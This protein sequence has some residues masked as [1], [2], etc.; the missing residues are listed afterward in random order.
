MYAEKYLQTKALYL[1]MTKQ[2]Q[3]FLS[4]SN[5]IPPNINSNI[6][7]KIG[8][9]GVILLT[10]HNS[11]P[12]VIIVHNKFTNKW[13]IP[14]GKLEGDLDPK[15]TGYREL[16]EESK[17]LFK[18][19]PQT[20]DG[21]VYIDKLNP[22]TQTI[23]RAYILFITTPDIQL[24]NDN[25][26]ELSRR[27]GLVPL[28]YMETDAMD[29]LYLEQFEADIMNDKGGKDLY[30]Y[31]ASGEP[32]IFRSRDKAVLRDSLKIIKKLLKTTPLVLNFN[33]DDRKTTTSY[34]KGLKCYWV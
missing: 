16:R 25:L 26:L 34:L 28:S 24:Y 10:L 19:S 3:E 20:L 12:A 32:I 22:D 17:G 21:A 13:D 15:E 2:Y 11:K 8:G 33:P 29:F 5:T 18:L 31:R 7:P 1:R 9:V 4:S 6:I 23:Y 14:G 30:T 27:S